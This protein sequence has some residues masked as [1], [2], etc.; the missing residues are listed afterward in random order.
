M[1]LNHSCR[2]GYF[3]WCSSV[4]ALALHV[5]HAVLNIHNGYFSPDFYKFLHLIVLFLTSVHYIMREG[6]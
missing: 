4:G 1:A 5:V 2:L 3:F 6:A